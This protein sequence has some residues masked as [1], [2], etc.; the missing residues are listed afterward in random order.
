MKGTARLIRACLTV[1]LV[2]WSDTRVL[3][4]PACFGAEETSIVDG[5]KVGVLVLLGIT[6]VVQGGF[7][8]FFIYLRR[9]AKRIAELELEDEWSALQRGEGTS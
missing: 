9:R 5:A 1:A 2:A 7:A 8:A 6:L 4:C 3:A